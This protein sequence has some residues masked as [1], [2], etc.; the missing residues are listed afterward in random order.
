[1]KREPCAG[2]G[3]PPWNAAI[4]VESHE[5]GGNL[6]PGYVDQ[7]EET[8]R[9][10]GV[11]SKEY[12]LLLQVSDATKT[13]LDRVSKGNLAGLAADFKKDSSWRRNQ[14]HFQ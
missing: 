11:E 6:A 7:M 3:I 1:M 4:R 8:R 5:P 2:H 14:C 9:E 13:Y 10:K 12:K